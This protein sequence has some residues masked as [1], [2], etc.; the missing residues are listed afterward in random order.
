[1]AGAATIC[2]AIYY[3]ITVVSFGIAAPKLPDT[4]TFSLGRWHWPVVIL[5]VLWL[6]VEIAI[7]TVPEEFHPGA[8]TAGGVIVAGLLLYP[9]IGRPNKKSR[10]AWTQA[11]PVP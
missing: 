10:R 2:A 4:H 3:L 1:M 5:A 7:L 11:L 9:F 8:K 6:L